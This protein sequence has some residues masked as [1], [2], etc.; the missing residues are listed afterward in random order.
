MGTLIDRAYV[1]SK[2]LQFLNRKNEVNE[3][4]LLSGR[5]FFLSQRKIARKNFFVAV[6]DQIEENSTVLSVN[7]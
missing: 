1:I 2:V 3:G 6:L 7:Y 5:H 4:P